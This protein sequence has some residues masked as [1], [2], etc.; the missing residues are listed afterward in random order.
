MPEMPPQDSG[1]TSSS[2]SQKV[3]W[4]PAGSSAVYCRSPY[5]KFVAGITIYA[6]R[7]LLTARDPSPHFQLEPL[8]RGCT[9]AFGFVERVRS[10]RTA[11]R[12]SG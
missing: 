4:C 5:S 6:R 3:H 9:A 12:T 11:S 2:V 1:A 10:A 7:S 8:P